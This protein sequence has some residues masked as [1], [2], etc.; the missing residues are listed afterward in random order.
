MA[1]AGNCGAT[2]A[3]PPADID[4][5][6]WWFGEDQGCYV[7]SVLE[8]TAFGVE[9]AVADLPVF[10]LGRTGG[11]GLKLRDGATISLEALKAE[12]ERFFPAWMD[13]A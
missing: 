3:A 6:A 13:Q 8:P 2:L 1:M 12:H 5:H 4:P 7:V 10:Q 11:T 9:A